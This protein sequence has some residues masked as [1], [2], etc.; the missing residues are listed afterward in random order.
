[1]LSLH[2]LY[3]LCIVI[4]IVSGEPTAKTLETLRTSIKHEANCAQNL[5]LNNHR[6]EGRCA[7]KGCSIEVGYLRTQYECR[8]CGK[9]SLW[10][11]EQTGCV[12]HDAASVGFRS[13]QPPPERPSV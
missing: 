4:P 6:N 9:H 12:Y 3:L 7:R 5:V 11:D 2:P 10:F 13:S 1:M 8:N